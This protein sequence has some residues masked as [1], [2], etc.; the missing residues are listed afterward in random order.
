MIGVLKEYLKREQFKAEMKDALGPV[1]AMAAEG[2]KPYLNFLVALLA[3]HFT[4]LL[5]ICYY[6]VRLGKHVQVSSCSLRA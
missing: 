1:V 6:L 3:V 5:L 2:A 4:F